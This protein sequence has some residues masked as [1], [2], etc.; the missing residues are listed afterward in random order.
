MRSS[1]NGYT[2]IGTPDPDLTTRARIR[3]A[4][5]VVF[6]DRGFRTGVREVAAAAGVSPGLVNHH[7]GS[8]NGLR[9]ACDEYVLGAIRAAKTE[10]LTRP[11]AAGLLHQLADIEEYA[12]LVAY[13]VRSYQS[14]GDLARTMFDHL[15]AN[16]EQY[17]EE[18]VTAGTLRP[19]RD[20]AARARYLTMQS[21]GSTML[22]LQ[23]RG[24]QDG[25]VDWG[26]AL[27]ELTDEVMLPAL[28]LYTEGLFTDTT[29]LD[30]IVAQRPDNAGDT[31]HE[32]FR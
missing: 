12:P 32:E 7:F 30:T 6:G 24:E 27:R 15:V 11:S 22:F 13:L 25:P 18:G 19:S 23:M 20:P 8:K 29:F 9:E 14:G 28:E 26:R 16:T 10:T 3:D 4:A 5:I 21:L 1:L 2:A 17:L 31:N